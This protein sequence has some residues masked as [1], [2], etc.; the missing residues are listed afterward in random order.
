MVKAL[1]DY[2]AREDDEL[3][4]SKHAVITNVNH[5]DGDKGWWR[6]D[7]GG[8]RQHLFPSS[9]VEEIEPQD[10]SQE[11]RIIFRVAGQ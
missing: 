1:Y 3:T 10:Q 2:T 7:Y 5:G 4:F 6:G 11:V 8:K 9:F